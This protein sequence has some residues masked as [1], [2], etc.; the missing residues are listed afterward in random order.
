MYSPRIKAELIPQLYQI[1]TETG[2][3]MTKV[4]DSMIREGIRRWHQRKERSANH[5]NN[6]VHSPPGPERSIGI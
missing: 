1:K 6:S 4:V 2:T 3:T 5:E